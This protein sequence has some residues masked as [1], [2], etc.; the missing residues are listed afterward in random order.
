MEIDVGQSKRNLPIDP[1]G[2]RAEC[3]ILIKP[4]VALWVEPLQSRIACS[5]PDNVGEQNVNT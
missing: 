4:S 1:V 2:L 5:L 3:T